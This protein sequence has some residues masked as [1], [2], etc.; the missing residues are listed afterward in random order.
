MSAKMLVA[1]LVTLAGVSGAA[2]QPQPIIDVHLHANS[3]EDFLQHRLGAPNEC[4][5][6]REI[7]P[8]DVAVV[9]PADLATFYFKERLAT[10]TKILNAAPTEAELMQRT[11]AILE[12]RN[13]VA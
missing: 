6:P 4:A 7:P 12:R 9:A 8:L 11:L 2:G 1:I 13:I 5:L 3:P 10:C